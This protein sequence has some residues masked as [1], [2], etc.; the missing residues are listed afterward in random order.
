MTAVHQFHP[1]LAPS[2]AI[3]NHVFALRDRL[4]S[5]GYESDA[6]AVDAKPGVESE[7]LSYRRLFRAVRPEDT[8]ILHFSMGN[9]VFDQLIKIPARRV[10]VY[11]NITPP[12]FFSGIND[13]AAAFAR[14][15]LRQLEQIAPAIELALGVSAFNRQDL[16]D[17]GFRRTAQVPILIDWK[18]YDTAPDPAVLARWSVFGRKLLFVGRISPNKRHDDLLRM[19]AY[20]RA[21]ID[22]EAQLLL[23]GSYRDHRG[24]YARLRELQRALGLDTAV[25]FTGGVSQS[26][27][28]A[29]YRQADTFV[30]LSEHEG[31][32]VPLLEAMRFDLPVV[33][34]DAAAIG[35]TVGGA[36]VLLHDR[37]L[38][39]AAEAAALVSEDT[40]LRAKLAAAG[41]TRVADFDTDK[42]AQRTREVLA[43]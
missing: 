12:E 10:L 11:H 5:W 23:V 39:Q 29:Y 35:E 6:Y 19:F 34:Y 14:L 28:C 41:R 37:D 2:D 31:F 16:D 18:R 36:G 1:V 13:H 9:E 32:G 3:S 21:V 30:S 26:E 8:L 42:V 7:A 20:Y 4:R 40:A 24:Y 25:T 22:P 43:L 15:G 17:M 27:L 33:A 38:A